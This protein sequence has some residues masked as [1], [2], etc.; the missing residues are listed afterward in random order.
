MENLFGNSYETVGNT[1]SDLLLKCR[2]EI[3]IQIGNKFIDLTSLLSK[4]EEQQ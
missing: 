3:K 1:E 4:L 2:G